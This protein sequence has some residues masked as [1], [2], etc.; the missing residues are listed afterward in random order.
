MKRVLTVLAIASLILGSLAWGASV[1]QRPLQ[2]AE[3][4]NAAD[5][6]WHL[7]HSRNGVSLTCNPAMI[8]KHLKSSGAGE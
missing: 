4:R 2:P 1:V 8:D 5:V 6:M 7:D 3:C